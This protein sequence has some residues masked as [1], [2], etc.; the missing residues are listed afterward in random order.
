[1]GDLHTI[2]VH[3]LWI[4]SCPFEILLSQPFFLLYCLLGI[5]CEFVWGWLWK[6]YKIS[7][8]Q[9]LSLWHYPH[10]HTYTQK[11]IHFGRVCFFS[12][13]QK[14][15]V[16]WPFPQ[17][18]LWQGY[19]HNH[20]YCVKVCGYVNNFCGFRGY[21]GSHFSHFPGFFGCFGANDAIL[22]IFCL[23]FAPFPRRSLWFLPGIGDN[24]FISLQNFPMLR[25][26]STTFSLSC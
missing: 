5:R 14:I 19:P 10:N 1:M 21:V 12:F 9:A 13:S 20:T 6:E 16:F 18:R 15:T 25:K 17:C 2:F 22:G 23:F 11:F 7:L 4:V 26:F 3:M 24:F 8:R